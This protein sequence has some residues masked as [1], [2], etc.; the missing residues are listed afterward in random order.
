MR[1]LWI[2]GVS[3]SDNTGE[4]AAMIGGITGEAR[5]RNKGR[6]SRRGGDSKPVCLA[7]GIAWSERSVASR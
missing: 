1:V 6:P 2:K 5:I 7:V 4:Q 3:I